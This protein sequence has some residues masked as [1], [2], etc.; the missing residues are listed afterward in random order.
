MSISK[1]S[2][3]F[4]PPHQ[5]NKQQRENL[6]PHAPK[7][8]PPTGYGAKFSGPYCIAVSLIDGDAGL[9]QFTDERIVDRDL[10]ALTEKITFEIDPE[11]EYPKNYTGEII[12]VLTDGRTVR[13]FQPHLRGGK[14]APLTHSDL[15]RK[16]FANLDFG[17][18]N[19]RVYSSPFT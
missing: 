12:G 8:R 14:N 5:K 6:K 2:I 15:V 4:K 19:E 18:M 11:N 17:R 13:A 9:A 7:Q 10:L 1:R 3:L 16:Y